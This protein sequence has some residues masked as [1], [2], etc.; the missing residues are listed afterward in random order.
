MTRSGSSGRKGVFV[1]DRTGWASIASMFFRRSEWIGLRP[2]VPRYRLAVIGGASPTHMSQRGS[3]SLDVGI[4][5]LC[6]LAATEP[7]EELRASAPVSA[8]SECRSRPCE[9]R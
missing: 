3:Q 4:H 2:R 9:S 1:Y 6:A 8:S 7:L 5:R